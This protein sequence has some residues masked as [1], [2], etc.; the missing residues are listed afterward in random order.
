MSTQPEPPQLHQRFDE[1][2]GHDEPP[3]AGQRAAT[4]SPS[5]GV[6]SLRVGRDERFRAIPDILRP[7]S[8]AFAGAAATAVQDRA[9]QSWG[10]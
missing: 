6:P 3:T 4:M 5:R 7:T 8:R 10:Y 9:N 1:I 2:P